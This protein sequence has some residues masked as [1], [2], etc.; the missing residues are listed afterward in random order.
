MF[1]SNS[2]NHRGANS[3]HVVSKNQDGDEWN[4]SQQFHYDR[5]SAGG[6]AAAAS[7]FYT[8]YGQDTGILKQPCP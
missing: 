3:P 8:I 6:I 2:W 1:L 7:I 4:A 5:T